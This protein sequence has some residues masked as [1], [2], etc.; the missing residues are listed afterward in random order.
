ML[1]H[2]FALSATDM[3]QQEFTERCLKL[4]GPAR[5]ADLYGA[6][7]P[8]GVPAMSKSGVGFGRQQQNASTPASARVPLWIAKPES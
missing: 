3:V 6:A 5:S 1:Q 8:F 7:A 4:H 2:S